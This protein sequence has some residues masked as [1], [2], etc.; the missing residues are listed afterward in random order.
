MQNQNLNSRGLARKNSPEQALA[1][2][3]AY[4]LELLAIGPVNNEAAAARY[5]EVLAKHLNIVVAKPC[6]I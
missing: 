1:R 4:R 2:F 6:N 3:E 5:R